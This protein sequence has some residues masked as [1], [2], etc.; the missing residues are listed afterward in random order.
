MINFLELDMHVWAHDTL[1]GQFEINTPADGICKLLPPGYLQY[2]QFFYVEEYDANTVTIHIYGPNGSDEILNGLLVKYVNYCWALEI[3]ELMQQGNIKIH[4]DKITML[5]DIELHSM[6]F[7]KEGLKCTFADNPRIFEQ[8]RMIQMFLHAGYKHIRLIP[9]DLGYTGYWFSDDTLDYTL[10]MEHHPADM[11]LWTS[12]LVPDW[13]GL[14]EQQVQE[15]CCPSYPNERIYYEYGSIT[16]VLPVII[17][18][19]EINETTIE[20]N[21]SR[22]KSEVSP[23][24]TN[25]VYYS[26]R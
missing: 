26:P 12:F 18:E 7:S 2:Q 21:C 3:M 22:L 20:R 25:L 5:H 11:R 19:P 9:K 15:L 10:K 24:L 8:L 6:E 16:V 17:A 14:D 4:L 1:A 23:I 13:L